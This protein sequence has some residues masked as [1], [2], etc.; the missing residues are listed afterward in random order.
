MLLTLTTVSCAA[1]TTFIGQTLEEQYNLHRNEIT[2]QCTAEAKSLMH[3]AQNRDAGVP[4]LSIIDYYLE[5]SVKE[6]KERTL[7]P[8]LTVEDVL[9]Q[10]GLITVIYHSPLTQEEI[11]NSQFRSCEKIS[12]DN[13]DMFYK[14]IREIK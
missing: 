11:F 4:M 6:Y 13:L 1:S 14:N 8:P 7:Y 10:I 2:V 5:M 9:L 12:L 3:I